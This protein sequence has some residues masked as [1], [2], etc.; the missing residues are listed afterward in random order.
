[1]RLGASS[2]IR[3]AKLFDDLVSD[4]QQVARYFQPEQSGGLQIDDQL[5]SGRLL[6]R[7]IGGFLPLLKLCR[8]RWPRVGTDRR[9][10]SSGGAGV[11]VAEGD[12]VV[13]EEQMACTRGQPSG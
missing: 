1:M 10:R 9:G 11:L 13:Y 6:Y 12:V 7:K 5:I 3:A 8:H 2:D 4:Q